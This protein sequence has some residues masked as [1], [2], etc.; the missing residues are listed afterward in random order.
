MNTMS[1]QKLNEQGLNE[2][3]LDL[4]ELLCAPEATDDLEDIEF[5]DDFD[6]AAEQDFI[7]GWLREEHAYNEKI[8]VTEESEEMEETHV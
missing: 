2:Q 1:E 5:D 6:E 3:E 8:R 7:E 4:M